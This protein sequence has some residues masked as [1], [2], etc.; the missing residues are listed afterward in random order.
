VARVGGDLAM[1]SIPSAG[2]SRIVALDWLR[3]AVMVLMAIDHASGVFN[4]GRLI[5]DGFTLYTPGTPL[6]PAQFLTRW[7][8]HLCAPTFVFLAGAALTLSTERRLRAGDDARRLDGFVVRR[9]LFIALL[10]PIWMSWALAPGHILLQVLY[11]IGGGLIAITGLRRLSNGW[12]VGGAVALLLGGEALVGLALTV[13][14]GAPTLPTALLLSGGQFGRLIV[15]YP[16]LP[17]LAIMM[18]GC[19]FGRFL[20]VAGPARAARRAAAA[21]AGA[22]G[23]FLAIRG[24]DG[25]GNMRL[26]RADVSLVQW[27]HVSKYPPSLS[28][29]ALELGLMALILAGL[30]ALPAR[31]P[32][33]TALEPL[34]VLG[35]TALFFYLL[36]VHVLVLVGSVLGLE[37]HTG[38]AGAWLGG[39]GVTALLYPLCRR[40]RAYKAAY[41]D[42]WARYV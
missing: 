30:L 25:Y 31:S 39:L 36:H 21:G 15:A 23:L 20:L 35:Q 37:H 24:L 32:V 16:L 13:S 28:Y 27:L 2:S 6:P 1:A 29:A 7:M 19:A 38:L 11:A 18:L 5:T 17:W 3:G 9:G 10:D 40:Y 33:T 42:G 41:P 4:E 34:R 14:G 8:T 22:L 12:L 26:L